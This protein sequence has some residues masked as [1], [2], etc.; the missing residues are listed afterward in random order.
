[1]KKL[2]EKTNIA[3]KPVVLERE[4]VKEIIHALV[5]RRIKPDLTNVKEYNAILNE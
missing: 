1:M 2:N 5:W 3:E 4:K